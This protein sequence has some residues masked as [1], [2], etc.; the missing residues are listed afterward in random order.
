MKLN[1]GRATRVV[2]EFCRYVANDPFPASEFLPYLRLAFPSPSSKCHRLKGV[3]LFHS[4]ISKTRKFFQPGTE[5][6]NNAFCWGLQ[7]SLQ[8]FRISFP[9]IK[10]FCAIATGTKGFC[11]ARVEYFSST[12]GESTLYWQ[13]AHNN[14]NQTASHTCCA[15]HR[16]TEWNRLMLFNP[17]YDVVVPTCN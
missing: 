12:P 9:L 11:V 10:E 4:N 2:N 6:I 13:T 14:I 3:Q 1:F 8:P 16:T 7:K 5:N 15:L 17:H